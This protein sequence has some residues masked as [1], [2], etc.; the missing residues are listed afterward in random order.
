MRLGIVSALLGVLLVLSVGLALASASSTA[1][2]FYLAAR[3]GQCLIAPRSVGS[4]GH[5]YVVVVSCANARHNFE[6]FS[7]QHGGWGR[8]PAPSN[9]SS[10]VLQICRSA[11]ARSAGHR[12]RAP[13]GVYGFWPDPGAEQARYGDSVICS[14]VLYPSYGALG[15]GRHIR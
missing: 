4:A 10:L 9:A 15:A 5:K 1:S 2:V 11:Y 14:Y 8:S 7:M 13:G 3:P 12:L 6:V